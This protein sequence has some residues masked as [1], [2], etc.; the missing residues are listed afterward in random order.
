MTEAQMQARI[1][2]HNTRALEQRDR[3]ANRFLA[4]LEALH[5]AH[6]AA[7]RTGPIEFNVLM[8]SSGGQ[9]GAF[10]TGVLDGWSDSDSREFRRPTFDIV[11]GVSTGALIA[12]FAI[13]GEGESLSRVAQLF[14][15]ADDSFAR[16]RG[17]LFFLP[18]RTSIFDTRVL[19]A[20]VQSEIDADV[21]RRVAE[22]HHE[23][24]ML[25]IGAVDL[26]L[27]RFHI[28]DMGAIAASATESDDYSLFHSALISSA[29]I[30]GAFPPVEID[31]VL[32]ADGAAALATFLGLDRELVN[33]VV[34]LFLARNP[35]AVTPQL[36]MWMIVNGHIDPPARLAEQGWSSV[37]LRS[38]EVITSYSLRATL[39][40]MQ[41]GAE[42]LGR[43][44]GRPVEFRYVAVPPSVEL[45]E[46]KSRLFDQRLMLEL[47]ALGYTLG[48]DPNAWRTE[49]IAPDI[50]GSS[51]ILRELVID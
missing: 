43:D 13:S 9:Y 37:A 16:I 14:K 7:G 30:P 41:L 49:P 22:A 24:R 44:L 19:Q 4:R 20:R 32:Y 28:W 5:R 35:D 15:Q 46:S 33:H 47:H 29:A 23:Q 3:F 42:L 12:P 51:I 38:A 27:G 26:D 48:S 1:A 31:G 18:W 39:R 17:M 21:V 10:G 25:L 34:A 45:P 40:Q 2:E 50:L 8:L 6:R 11:T 36:R